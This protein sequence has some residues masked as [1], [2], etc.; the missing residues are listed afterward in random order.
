MPA[1]C[2][3][4]LLVIRTY[5]H[6]ALPLE[7][8][9]VVYANLVRYL[10]RIRRHPMPRRRPSCDSPVIQLQR[11]SLLDGRARGPF[12]RFRPHDPLSVEVPH[13]RL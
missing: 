1:V 7:Q 2:R 11:P 3:A 5:F 4:T 10:A 8:R 9:T 13:L 12:L 6:V